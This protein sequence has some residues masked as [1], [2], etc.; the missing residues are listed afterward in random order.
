MKKITLLGLLVLVMAGATHQTASAWWGR[1]WGWGGG[2]GWNRPFGWGLGWGWNRPWGG[3][4]YGY[5]GVPA[6]RPV[7]NY[8]LQIQQQRL[9]QERLKTEQLRREVERSQAK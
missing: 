8:N 6:Y 7:P 9:E 1:G 4:P 2:W 5:Y 3:Y